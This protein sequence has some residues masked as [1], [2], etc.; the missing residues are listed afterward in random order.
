MG[1]HNPSLSEIFIQLHKN[2]N[3]GY[4]VWFSNL[5][6]FATPS[7]EISEEEATPTGEDDGHERGPKQQNLP[8]LK[9]KWEERYAHGNLL[10]TFVWYCKQEE[11]FTPSTYVDNMIF[12]YIVQVV[13]TR[14]QVLPLYECDTFG[15]FVCLLA[16]YLGWL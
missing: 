9:R 1:N 16:L 4:F 7:L 15:L 5:Q 13:K 12:I 14:R 8:V 2:R 10:M 6:D 3:Y 11:N